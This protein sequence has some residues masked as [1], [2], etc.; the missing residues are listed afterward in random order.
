MPPTIARL[1]TVVIRNPLGEDTACMR[2]TLAPDMLRILAGNDSRGNDCAMLYEFGTLFDATRRT[3]E[4]LITESPAL[5][6]GAYGK[7]SGFLRHSRRGAG[8]VRAG[9]RK[10]YGCTRRRLLLSSRPQR[11]ADAW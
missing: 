2:T 1:N 6:I 4:G 7:D 3:E 11:T 5:S 10:R 8:A 9:G